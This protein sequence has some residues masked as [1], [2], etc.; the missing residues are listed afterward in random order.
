SAAGATCS[1]A[2]RGDETLDGQHRAEV[3]GRDLLVADADAEALLQERHELEDSERVDDAGVGE[4]VLVADVEAAGGGGQAVHHELPDGGAR[5]AV[6]AEHHAASAT[7]A[8]AASRVRSVLPVDVFGS[9][10][11]SSM[12]SGT[13]PSG[14]R[15]AQWVCSTP[16]VS[17]SPARTATKAR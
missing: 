8:S 12:R 11:R 13:M 1:A 7:R 17:V 3:L 16:A 9:S 6:H 14:I 10:A 4:V 5:V 2:P 15:R